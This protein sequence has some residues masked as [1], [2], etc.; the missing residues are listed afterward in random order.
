MRRAEDG[1]IMKTCET[2]SAEMESVVKIKGEK[3][4]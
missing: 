4:L 1:K 3:H 2:W